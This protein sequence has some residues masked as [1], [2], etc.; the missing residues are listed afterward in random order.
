MAGL[1][2]MTMLFIRS[3]GGVSHHPDEAVLPADVQSA[4]E[5]MVAFLRR[6]AGV[7]A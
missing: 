5:V 7:V 6:L 2:P 3:P 4:L 1:A